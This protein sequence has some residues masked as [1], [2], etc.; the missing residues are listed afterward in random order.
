ME[1]STVKDRELQ[2]LLSSKC[3]LPIAS[4]CESDSTYASHDPSGYGNPI[5]SVVYVH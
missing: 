3:Q 4:L 5:D 1:G 2:Q